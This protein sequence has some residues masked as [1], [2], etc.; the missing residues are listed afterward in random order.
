[1]IDRNGE[2]E[3]TWWRWGIS[4]HLRWRGQNRSKTGMM[5]WDYTIWA[6]WKLWTRYCN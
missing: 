5:M 1:M 2:K 6:A 4:G 3:S